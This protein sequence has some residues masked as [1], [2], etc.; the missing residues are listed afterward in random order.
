MTTNHD[1]PAPVHIHFVLDRSGS[2]DAIRSD[3][4]GGFNSFLR[5]QQ[6]GTGACVMTLVQF[7]DQD[8]YEVLADAVPVAEMTP[9]TEASFV[10]RGTT[11]LYDAM[12]HAIANATIRAERREAAGDPPEDILFVTF[13][14]GMENASREYDRAKVFELVKRREDRG[15][16]FAYLG[17]N[18]DAYAESGKVGMAKGSTAAWAASP[19]G[20]AGAFDSLSR[21]TSAYRAKAPEARQAA[22]DEFFDD[23]S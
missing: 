18:Q 14:D 13:T 3:V 1:G 7:D 2:M 21:A 10:P 4:I 9:L 6:A 16:T 12:G 8:P 23:E 20:T 5:E 22:K 17:A 11:P 19:A 15:W